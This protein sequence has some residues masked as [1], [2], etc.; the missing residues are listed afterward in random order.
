MKD[1]I[2][3]LEF[4]D[5]LLIKLA[6][7]H[8]ICYFFN[9]AALRESWLTDMTAILSDQNFGNRSDQVEAALKKQE[10]ISA[11]I[12]ARVRILRQSSCS[13]IRACPFALSTSF[14]YQNYLFSGQWLKNSGLV[15]IWVW[16]RIHWCMVLAQ[17]WWWWC[18]CVSV[19]LSLKALPGNWTL[20][21]C[22]LFLLDFDIIL[23]NLNPNELMSF[24]AYEVF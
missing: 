6:I 15:I 24:R 1:Y 11:D 16:C 22:F 3:Q 13:K 17:T 14:S 12:E 19:C 18:V 5:A 4:D 2:I 20:C 23:Q 21:I 7:I 10:A 8:W 9:Q